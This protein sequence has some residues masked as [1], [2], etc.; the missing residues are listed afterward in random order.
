VCEWDGFS[1][2]F[3]N[4]YRLPRRI[5][6][7][8]VHNEV[9]Y[10]VN[11]FGQIFG[12]GANSFKYITEFP[13][14]NYG[15]SGGGIRIGKRACESDGNLV[16]MLVTTSNIKYRV[17]D[18]IWTFSPETGL[19]NH[20]YSIGGEDSN[21]G[22]GKLNLAGGIGVDR[23]DGKI[24][25]GVSLRPDVA[26][27]TNYHIVSAEYWE[28]DDFETY[29]SK[30]GY[31][32]T[33]RIRAESIEAEWKRIWVN[34]REFL[35]NDANNEIIVKVLDGKKNFLRGGA[36]WTKQITWNAKNEL[37][38]DSPEYLPEWLKEGHEA[39]V[40]IGQNAG[41]QLTI[42]HFEDDAGNT[43]EAQSWSSGDTVHIF[44]TADSIAG[45]AKDSE[46]AFHNWYEIGRISGEGKKNY[47][48]P[49]TGSDKYGN[50]LNESSE[51]K[52][53]IIM[54]GFQTEIERIIPTLSD[55]LNVE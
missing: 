9:P 3:N 51:K 16:R 7:G 2:V 28:Q 44:F 39:E 11:N 46:F 34:F 12:K 36:P 47:A 4:I 42:D 33:P 53:K 6:S 40:L 8:F 25:C 13:N 27:G 41:D 50:V 24:L 45:D 1:E 23:G 19:L 32:V 20:T 52:F 49:V 55:V 30:L 21:Y 22:Y 37:V 26:S 15:R 38:D 29:S 43:I 31:I 18:G 54:K 14:Y 35:K 17:R 48:F 10:F 5:E